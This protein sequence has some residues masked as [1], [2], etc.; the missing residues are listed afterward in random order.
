MSA[1]FACLVLACAP[2]AQG[3]ELPFERFGSALLDA[4]GAP[5]EP[6]DPGT[7]FESE[8]LDRLDELH[9]TIDL[10]ALQVWVPL[11][12]V[13]PEGTIED[14]AFA[15]EW[16]GVAETLIAL[17]RRWCAALGELEGARGEETTRAL[18]GLA[19]WVRRAG[20]K[21]RPAA[22]DECRSQARAVRIALLGT[23]EARP[24]AVVLAPTRAQFL[25]LM[26]AVGI[27]QPGQQKFLWNESARRSLGQA[28]G[29]SILALSLCFGPAQASDS[30]FLG[31]SVD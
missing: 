20:N 25:A 4:A 24:L 8:F 28:L 6:L 14:V 3:T 11:R 13:G 12:A 21:S 29:P 17:E 30:P 7:S 15:R 31:Q 1:V 5:A 16:K 2:P 18:D 27:L 10:G 19:G 9:A 22:D 23:A 26:G